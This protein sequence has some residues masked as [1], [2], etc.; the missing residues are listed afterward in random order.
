MKIYIKNQQEKFKQHLAFF[1]NQ[2]VMLYDK[3]ELKEKTTTVTIDS[4]KTIDQ[5]DLDF[6][7][8]YKLF[9]D[10]IISALCEWE[11][12]KRSMKIGD[13]IVQQAFLP[14]TKKLSQKVIFGVR[15]NEIIDEPTKKGYSYE[16]LVGHVEKGLSIFTVE[17][18]GAD[19]IFK[20][21][22][23]SMPGSFMMRLVGP[24]F[25]VPYQTFCTKKCLTNVKMQLEAQ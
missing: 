21:H 9:P 5:L 4:D 1:K 11:D 14:P 12:E 15:I 23:F 20:I 2:S 8:D 17:N 3:N 16:T 22:T 10:N 24:L 6:L 25:S 13:T 7:F 18:L 19:L